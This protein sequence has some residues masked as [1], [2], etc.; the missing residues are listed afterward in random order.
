M[1]LSRKCLHFL[2]KL[3]ETPRGWA[4]TSRGTALIPDRSSTRLGQIVVTL[5]NSQTEDNNFVA[6]NGGTFGRC[7]VALGSPGDRTVDQ[8]WRSSI[9]T[10]YR[11]RSTAPHWHYD[12][13]AAPVGCPVNNRPPGH[14]L[15]RSARGNEPSPPRRRRHPRPRKHSCSSTCY[16]DLQASLPD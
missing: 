3:T 16:S 10:R 2:Y 15:P 6:D 8:S 7:T 4:H 1:I 5:R 12:N 9:A 11:A 13:R 14:C